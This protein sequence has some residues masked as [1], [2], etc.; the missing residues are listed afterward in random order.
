M[1]FILS[2]Q[3][4]VYTQVLEAME[5]GGATVERVKPRPDA[6]KRAVHHGI[7]TPAKLD[8]FHTAHEAWCAAKNVEGVFEADADFSRQWTWRTRSLF[9]CEGAARSEWSVGTSPWLALHG[10][11]HAH[12]Q[13]PSGAAR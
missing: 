5:Q 7:L 10:Y 11:L 2:P 12:L 4:A 1:S 13:R 6:L 3:T 8:F 9:F